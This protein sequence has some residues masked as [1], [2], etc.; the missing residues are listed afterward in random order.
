MVTSCQRM[1]REF[2]SYESERRGTRTHGGPLKRT[3]VKLAKGGMARSTVL[4]DSCD[5]DV[6][7]WPCTQ[8]GGV[9]TGQI[10]T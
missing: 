8:G 9:S 2:P 10:S 1:G 3:K 6:P 7:H 4:V 5:A